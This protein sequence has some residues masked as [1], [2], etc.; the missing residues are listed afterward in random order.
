MAEQKI[1]I[2]SVE[3]AEFNGKE[4]RKITDADGKTWNL[5]EKFKGLW[6][7]LKPGTVL[8]AEI[9]IYLT[10]PYI[11]ECSVE[12]WGEEIDNPPQ[13]PAASSVPSIASKPPVAYPIAK[14]DNRESFKADPAKL[15]TTM[16]DTVFM[17]VSD[18]AIADKI[19]V[20]EIPFYYEQFLSLL[21]GGTCV[22]SM[23]EVKDVSESSKPAIATAVV[24]E[25]E[26]DRAKSGETEGSSGTDNDKIEQRIQERI[27]FVERLKEHNWEVGKAVFTLNKTKK[28]NLSTIDNIP[29]YDVAYKELK[30][31]EK[32]EK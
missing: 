28:Y 17:K 2:V 30:A 6:Q 9:G 22:L 12:E 29:D 26:A 19:K 16:R 24:K 18:L 8:N 23:K 11:K 21:R 25:V 1:T 3:K 10:K 31:L 5:K 13:P 32:W 15:D 14:Q 7:D 20:I 27:A 4:Y